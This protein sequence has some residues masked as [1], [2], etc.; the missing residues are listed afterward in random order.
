MRKI[1]TLLL[2]LSA[3]AFAS[4]ETKNEKQKR[5]DEQLKIEMENEKKYAR[6]QIFYTQDNYNFKGAE[7]NPKSLDTIPLLEPQDDFD[8]DSVYD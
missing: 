6:E 7:V 4:N 2:V 1:F 8:M 3:L 5:I